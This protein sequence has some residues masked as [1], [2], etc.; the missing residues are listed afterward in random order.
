MRD[1]RLDL[2][3]NFLIFQ[4]RIGAGIKLPPT[5]RFSLTQIGDPQVHMSSGFQAT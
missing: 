5:C 4:P 1:F 2:T 3:A